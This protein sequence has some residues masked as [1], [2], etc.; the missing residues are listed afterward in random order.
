MERKTT[1]IRPFIGAQNF[2][3]SKSFYCDP[4]F[5]EIAEQS[6]KHGMEMFQKGDKPHLD[7]M[8]QMKDLM[9]SPDDMNEWFDSKRKEFEALPDEK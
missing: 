2:E 7:A 5:E 1:S 3:I 6:K 4:G 8:N 9:K